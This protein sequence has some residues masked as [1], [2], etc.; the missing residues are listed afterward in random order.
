MKNEQSH[1]DSFPKLHYFPEIPGKHSSNKSGCAGQAGNFQP[2]DFNID[3]EGELYAGLSVESI[4]HRNFSGKS[5][6]NTGE[7]R[8]QAYELGYAEGNKSG[9]ESERKNLVSA[10][11]T[12]NKGI[13]Q[14]D[15]IKTELYHNA[16]KE[17]VNLA[18]AIAEKI[19]KHEVSIKKD[20]ILNVLKQAV[21]KIVDSDKIKIRLNPSDLQFL[22]AQNNEYPNLVDDMQDMTFE[23]DATILSGGC[24]IET[25]LGDID[26]RINKQFEAVEEAFS[27]EFRKTAD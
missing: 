15:E 13:I 11:N 9:V 6:K 20:T 12:L 3:R 10:L 27:S 23:E 7:T 25:K 21:N 5:Q 19:V 2:I 26:A 1:H 18:I 4:N 8:Q 17:V 22:N 14:L 16:E 24:L